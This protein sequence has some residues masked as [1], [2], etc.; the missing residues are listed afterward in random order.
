[1]YGPSHRDTTWRS[2]PCEAGTFSVVA[3]Y[4]DTTDGSECGSDS[5]WAR[6][7]T[8]PGYPDLDEL[9]CLQMNYPVV[10]TVPI[11]TCLLKTGTGSGTSFSQVPCD[12]ANVVVTGRTDTYDDPSFC[13]TDGA[14]WWHPHGYRDLGF[15][16]CLGPVN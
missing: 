14:S 12:E 10:G 5:D 16:T 1:V 2:E 15:T 3:R 11:D 7:F 13:G 8:V 9:L 6:Q 4:R